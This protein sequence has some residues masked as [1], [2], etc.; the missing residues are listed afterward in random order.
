MVLL[1]I[2]LLIALKSLGSMPRH[3]IFLYLHCIVRVSLLSWSAPSDQDWF[4]VPSK[5]IPSR[6][7]VYG[8]P[9]HLLSDGFIFSPDHGL[10]MSDYT[11]LFDIK[12]QGRVESSTQ[13]TVLGAFT[14]LPAANALN[15]GC[16][17]LYTGTAG[18]YTP[19]RFYISDGSSWKD[20][21][22]VNPPVDTGLSETSENP[23]QNKAVHLALKGKQD[24][25]TFDDAPVQGS[26]RPVKSHGI[27]TALDGK[28][29]S[30]ATAAKAKADQLGNI[31]DEVYATKTALESKQDKLNIVTSPS[32]GSSAVITAGGVATALDGKVDKDGDKVLSDNNYT[33]AEKTKLGGIAT[34]AQVNVIESIKVDGSPLTPTSKAV[35]IDLA[36]RLS[37]YALKT[38]IASAYRVKGSITYA[39]MIALTTAEIG[40]TYS[41]T[42]KGGMNYVC[43]VAGT[44]GESSWDAIGA[45]FDGSGLITE[46]DLN[47]AVSGKQDQLTATN[48]LTLSGATIG[49]SNS[50]TAA[51]NVGSATAVPII[52]YD[53]Q[54]HI[55]SVSTAAMYPPTS[56]GSSGQ[57]W[58]SSGNGQGVWQTMDTAPTQ[59]SG[60]AITSGAVY[61]A[62]AGKQ[63][64]LVAGTNMDNTPVA[65]STN[66]IT[67]GA[68][69]L[70]VDTLNEAIEASKITLTGAVTT[71]TTNNLSASKILV[72][73]SNGK[74][75]V[76]SV[77]SDKLTHLTNVTSDIQT[78]INS[79]QT[80]LTEVGTA[81][82]P[83]YINSAGVPTVGTYTLGAA[84][85]KGVSTAITSGDSNLVT[86]GAVFSAINTTNGNVSAL[87]TSV[88][89]LETAVEGKQAK[90]TVSTTEPTV[91]D[92]EEGELWAV[93]E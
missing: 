26:D 61:S 31:I 1:S 16:I 13:G 72:S 83:I 27:Y 3:I 41:V 30:D 87:Q 32:A 86:S 37:A 44:A 73:D 21:S 19:G 14:T 93:V 63:A 33:D 70:A 7:P 58:K 62:L 43:T 59:S 20:A 56:A 18:T 76:S 24:T 52:S 42:D 64:K 74:V 9:T 12:V 82:R 40:D 65:S 54:G 79:K 17:A 84:C 2:L 57:Y 29:D 23:V 66:P 34:G 55:K 88:S 51:S 68:V 85:A 25:L 22:T 71:I 35:N 4:F 45:F 8:V 48:G 5:H 38:D 10:P 28:L 80:K 36:T 47:N 67:S 6:G 39:R 46:D 15:S 11:H 60:N 78:Q 81:T 53:A 69:K 89:T 91:D 92:L 77:A 90:I 50:V 49:H 75:A